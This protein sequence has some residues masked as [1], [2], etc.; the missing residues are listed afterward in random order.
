MFTYASNIVF[1]CGLRCWDWSSF[2]EIEDQ[3]LILN[4]DSELKAKN[5][6]VQIR[7]KDSA[8]DIWF[9][10]YLVC[11]FGRSNCLKFQIAFPYRNWQGYIEGLFLVTQYVVLY[12][13]S[14]PVVLS[15]LIFFSIQWT[16]FSLTEEINRLISNYW[17]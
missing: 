12:Y 1:C 10:L 5:L 16:F 8:T 6:K 11:V 9:F 3:S 14:E 17:L 7:L 2:C 15:M 4:F 13:N